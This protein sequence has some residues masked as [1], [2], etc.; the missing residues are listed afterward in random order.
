MA[1]LTLDR[2]E[3]RNAL[4]KELIAELLER[5]DEAEH[6]GV[7]AL[8]L[9]GEGPAFCAGGDVGWMDERLGDPNATHEA[10]RANLNRLVERLHGFPAPT[11]AAVHGAAIGA[12]LGLALACDV[13]IAAE[14]A[15][16]GATHARLGLTPDAGT[17]WFLTQ[18]LGPKRALD[19]V[20]SARTF[21]GAEAYEWGLVTDT[22]PASEVPDAARS[23]AR[24][25]AEGPTQAHRKAREL[26]DQAAEGS[27]AE[28][29]AREA[30]A[31]AMM[32]ATE[33]QRE[34]VRA[35]H[36]DR[37]PRFEGR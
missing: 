26:V 36:E 35:F 17:S 28:T 27:L 21:T 13:T 31:Q 10:I 15:V 20:L 23:R 30:D 16:L 9:E 3:K 2:P 25:L 24:K 34:G 12:G 1:R 22:V 7:R 19:L 33:D 18:T 14:E 5:L 29:L 6:A 11:V 37:E 4:S 8:L 32:Y